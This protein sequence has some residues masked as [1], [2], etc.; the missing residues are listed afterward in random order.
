MCNFVWIKMKLMDN[1]RYKAFVHI[2]VF[3]LNYC[4]STLLSHL[5]IV[6]II[7]STDLNK[8]YGTT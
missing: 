3:I 6:S 2:F 4:E 1:I 7:F 5:Q 8:Y